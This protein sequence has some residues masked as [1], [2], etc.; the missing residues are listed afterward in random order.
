MKKILYTIIL[1]T[2]LY[3]NILAQD[4]KMGPFIDSLMNKMTLLEK[5]GQL[6]LSSG[7]G[8]L[9]VATEGTG[10]E[11]YI[12]QGLIGASGG[13]KNQEVAV[14]ESRLGIPLLAGED[15]IHG[16]KTIFPIPL[17]MACMWDM[18]LVEKS[19]HIAATEAG[20][21]GICWTYSPMVDICRDPRWGRI[22]E[23]A[24]EDPWYGSQAAKAF[25][26]G[27]QG[28]DLSADNTIMAC[29]KHFA[30]YGAAEAGRDYNTVDMGR[31]SMLQNYLPPYKAAVD[32]GAGSIMTSF[33]VID[34]IPATGNKWLLDDLLRKQW[35]FGGF[36]VTDYSAINEMR[37]HG[38][39]DLQS[40][41]VLALKAGV[42]MDMAGQSY[43][44]T[45]SKSMEEGKVTQQEIDQACRRVLEA[46]YKLGL[47]ENP[48]KYFNEEKAK[49]IVL[50]Q[51]HIDASREIAVR[52][53][54]LLKNSKN[55]LPLKKSGRIAVVGPLADSKADMLGTWAWRGSVEKVVTILEGIKNATGNRAE[56]FYAKGSPLTTDPFLLNRNKK[57]E[58]YIVP[59]PEEV[60]QLLEEA[61]NT[62]AKADIIVAVLGE[63]RDWSGEA[64]SRADIGIPECQRTLL[65]EMLATGKPVVLVLS[66]GRPLTLTWENDHV[67]AI[68]EAW[69]G[70]TEAGNALADVLF[71]DF[72]PSG[73]IT[74]TFPLCVGQI[75]IYYNHKN[76]GRPIIEDSKFTSKYLDIPN[77]PLYP[78]G[79]GLSYTTFEYSNITLDKTEIS[80]NETITAKITVTNTGKRDGEE[81]V[82][83][84]IRDL[85]GSVSRPVK[86]LKGYKKVM[87]EAGKSAEITFTLNSED[88]AFWRKDMTF[89]TEPGDFELY[90][91]KNSADVQTSKFF[92]K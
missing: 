22:A 44:S 61:K 66:N 90:I 71:G 80:E 79:Y 68:I 73:K 45:L 57:K 55:I 62:V 37:E 70:G 26:K 11:N 54:V 60:K 67:D 31:R 3:A 51:K 53:I 75:P 4:P 76:T 28:N 19:A 38:M 52:S 77:E 72:N 1:F 13:R 34:D 59:S 63:T 29:V 47:F 82:Q 83:L 91:G 43:I 50:C 84:Y 30:L 27:Y 87:V 25:V 81:I 20:V 92:L 9:L 65:K 74:A 33:N 32:A 36:I 86:E 89:G 58:N 40:L 64:S 23:G 15:V 2:G 5:L 35:G 42:D 46:K 41:A 85:V 17:A 48:F 7:V 88:L 14:K 56:V 8:N 18:A 39:G 24:G 21:S 12:R 49:E 6:N 16:Y 69:Q 78:F 10:I